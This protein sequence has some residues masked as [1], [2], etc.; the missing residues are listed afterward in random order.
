MRLDH[1]GS[2]MPGM[3]DKLVSRSV[4][5]HPQW[6]ASVDHIVQFGL[7]NVEAG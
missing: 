4:H 6:L 7:I 5:F 2:Q 1:W 3:P